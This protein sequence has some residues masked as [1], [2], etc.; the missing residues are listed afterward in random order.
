[1]TPYLLTPYLSP[2]AFNPAETFAYDPVGNR[3]TS[4]RSATHVYD[5]LNRLLEDDTFTYTYDNNGNLKTKTDKI[6]LQSTTYG[7]DAENRLIQ[8]ITPTDTVQYQYDGFG[9]RIARILNGTT[10]RYIY[11]N[12][13]ILLELD[14]NDNIKARYT[15]GPGIDEP[16]SVKRDTNGDG[17][18]D[19]TYYYHRDGLGS[20]TTMTNSAGSV[21]QSY[22]YDAFGNITNQ[23]GAVENSYTYTGREWDNEA[24]LYY[25]RVG[26]YDANVGRFINEDPRRFLGGVNFYPYVGNS[27]M[28]RVDPFGL[29]FGLWDVLGDTSMEFY[30]NCPKPNP[31]LPP[32]PGTE[33]EARDTTESDCGLAG[34]KKDFFT[35]PDHK[36]QTSYRGTGALYGKQCIYKDNSQ[37]ERNPEYAGTDDSVPPFDRDG[38]F[39]LTCLSGH[40]NCDMQR[41]TK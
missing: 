29:E 10:T 30:V 39:C 6:T 35:H 12:E 34:Y 16:L 22:T 24:G 8:V 1:L 38:G 21:V 5:N 17:V 4:H 36:W 41:R 19:T 27:P 23:T 32:C 2:Q 25:Y 11:D 13:D 31:N 26:Y 3:L 7:Y 37:L 18:L 9:R 28:N 14:V 33:N 15:H 40:L 20:I